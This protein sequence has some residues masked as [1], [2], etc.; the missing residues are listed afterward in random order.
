M[1]PLGRQVGLSCIRRWDKQVS[2]QCSSMVSASGP[3][4]KFLPSGLALIYPSDGILPGNEINPTS[5][6][7]GQCFIIAVKIKDRCL[8]PLLPHLTFSDRVSDWKFAVSSRLTSQQGLAIHLS[9]FPSS[10][11]K[12]MHYRVFTWV[13]RIQIQTQQAL[14]L[15]SP[16]CSI[17]WIIYKHFAQKKINL[18]LSFFHSLCLSRQGL[19]FG[20]PRDSL[21]RP[22]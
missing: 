11:V 21:C 18:F 13:L 3:P 22:G 15:L 17:Y 14:Y 7:F 19:F 9:Q 8:P 2:K 12:D 16:L 5:M 20:C 1:L 6:Y 4:F 10:G